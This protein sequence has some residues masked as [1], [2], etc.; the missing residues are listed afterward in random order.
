[1]QWLISFHSWHDILNC[2]N[3]GTRE[4]VVVTNLQIL[5][6]LTSTPCGC[7]EHPGNSCNRRLDNTNGKK[8]LHIYFKNKASREIKIELKVQQSIW[9]WIQNCL[10]AHPLFTLQADLTSA[11]FLSAHSYSYG[12]KDTAHSE[13][14]PRV[15]TALQK[16]WKKTLCFFFKLRQRSRHFRL[17]HSR[18]L[19]ENGKEFR[20]MK[21]E[22]A[23]GLWKRDKNPPAVKV[24]CMCGTE[25]SGVVKVYRTLSPRPLV[26]LQTASLANSV[27]NPSTAWQQ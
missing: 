24:L 22:A 18:W 20:K 15:C 8:A 21:G 13:Q 6:P 5:R 2:L 16:N 17:R 7:L 25:R 26:L 27:L 4:I 3:W 10:Q 9:V 1:M 19:P 12:D 11:H 23:C 14:Q